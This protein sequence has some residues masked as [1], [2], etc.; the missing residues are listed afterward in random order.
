[1][2][3]HCNKFRSLLPQLGTN[4]LKQLELISTVTVS[5]KSPICRHANSPLRELWV[6]D[7]LQKGGCFASSH[8]RPWN[9]P[10][11]RQESP[12]TVAKSYRLDPNIECPAHEEGPKQDALTQPEVILTLPGLRP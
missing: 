3:V 9:L 2:Q 4:T 7:P 10:D 6:A 12:H 8:I 11:G 5:W 1:M